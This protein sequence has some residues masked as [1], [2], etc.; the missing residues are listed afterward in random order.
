[1]EIDY[2]GSG[3][4]FESQWLFVVV[5]ICYGM[6][7]YRA[8][9][10]L[11]NVP[12][13]YIQ[14]F[15]NTLTHEAKSGVYNFQL[16]E[17]W[18]TLN[19]DLL[20]KALEITRV[21]PAHPFYHLYLY[22]EMVARKPTTKEGGQKKTTSKA[23]KP[24]R[25]TLVKKPAPA[26]QTKHV[27]EKTTQP[28]PTKKIRK[29]KVAKIHKG[30]SYLLLIDEDEQV[31]HEPEP[32]KEDDEY[33][34]QRGIQMSLESFQAPIGEVAIHE[35]TSGVTQS[36]LVVEGNGKGIATDEQVAQ[37]LMELKHPKGKISDT[38]SPPDA[39]TGV[40]A[41]RSD[42][43]GDTEIL[44]V[45]KEKGEDV[46][47]TVDLEEQI[48]ELNE[49]Q[50]GS[51]PRQVMSLLSM[52]NLDDAFINGDQFLYDKPTEEEPATTGTTTTS[53][54]PPPSPQQQSTA[55]PALDA[56]VATQ[57]QICANFEKKNKVQDQTTQ[58]L[59]SRIF[60]LENHDLYSKIDKYINENIKEVVQNA[61]KAPVRDAS[62]SY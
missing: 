1:M 19:V 59:S 4:T 25:P 48:V 36:L 60:T 61:L 57:E 14:Q 28:S 51:N 34:L 53:L 54:P 29:G 9:T 38:L 12:T 13:I 3:L 43:E 42:S 8:F 16:N 33:N 45:G 46:S 55:D 30:K 44:N 58:A 18:F 32:Q 24:K 62:E 7:G 10:A 26:K 49:G 6:S 5:A 50:A 2:W 31:Q 20:H 39:E 56:R 22:L 21:D 37:S 35:P 17:Q 52:K 47:N 27:K 23:D 15:Y 11:E 40:E 41:E